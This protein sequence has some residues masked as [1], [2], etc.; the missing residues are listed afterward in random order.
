MEVAGRKNKT[1]AAVVCL[2]A[3]LMF[4]SSCSTSRHAVTNI[5]R[6]TPVTS[7]A[8]DNSL[9]ADSL[10]VEAEKQ[11]LWGNPSIAI[12]L[13]K[14]FL[15]LKPGNA[16]A[17]YELA[18]LN[19]QLGNTVE[20]LDNARQAIR[21]DSANKWLGIA[22]AHALAMNEKYDSAAGYFH[23]LALNHQPQTIYLFNEA[24]MLS[25]TNKYE[26]ALDIINQIIKKEGTNAS[27]LYQKQYLL[28]KSGKPDSAALAIQQLIEMEPDNARFQ[29]LMTKLYTDNNQ[30]GA[31]ISFFK[32]L[33]SKDSSNPNPD[34][35]LS[36]AVLY[37]KEG[38]DAAFNDYVFKAFKDPD[39]D[40]ED[41]I[42]FASPYL[43]YVEI[44]S[45]D[46]E[47]ALSLCKLIV[48]VH[49]ENAKAYKFYGDMFFQCKMPDSALKEYRKAL[50]LDNSDYEVWNQVMLLYA[51]EGRNDSLMSISRQATQ[52][53]PNQGGA[54]Y[55]QGMAAFFSAQYESS[56][57][58]LRQSLQLGVKDKDLQ[59]R[60]Y[61]TM[62]NAYNNLKNYPA[63]DSCFLTAIRLNPQDDQTLNNYSFYLAE[64]HQHLRFAMQMIKAAVSLNPHQE[65]Y[66]DTYAWVLYN[67]GKYKEA[68]LWMEK[69]LRYPGASDH[70]GFLEH[71]GD[72][73]YKTHDKDEA[74]RYWKRAK[75]KGGNSYWLN[76]K[77]LHKRIPSRKDLSNN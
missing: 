36:L 69:V 4:F 52:Q 1:G 38:N 25:K 9:Y 8:G 44:D 10:F 2:S 55:F 16:T 74:A 28:Q 43:K 48:Q 35:M 7:V 37:K 24:L 70:P 40:I 32:S 56:I 71:Y 59:S 65:N 75:E 62:G 46:K 45:T 20:T 11:K 31:G 53:F 64:R 76:W 66:E 18:L 41:K 72:I 54:W 3:G 17:Y 12:Y 13:F 49:P 57:Q 42:T 63:S 19:G 67:L 77:I 27:L 68:R 26:A 39:F 33:L 60:I 5:R 73:L 23:L 14:E 6:D 61:A 15:K 29:T 22:Y 50:S 34:A 51:G 47:E 21:S 30:T 58:S